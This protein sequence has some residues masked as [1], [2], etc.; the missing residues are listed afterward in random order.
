[1]AG[2]Q[3][4]VAADPAVAA[5]EDP[6]GVVSDLLRAMLTQYERVFGVRPVTLCLPVGVAALLEAHWRRQRQPLPGDK[7]TNVDMLFGCAV[8]F[9]TEFR[10]MFGSSFGDRLQVSLDG[11][12]TYLPAPNGVRTAYVVDLDDDDSEHP[13]GRLLINQTAEGI[14]KDVYRHTFN[15]GTSSITVEE[16]VE[17][18]CHPAEDD[19]SLGVRS[20][21]GDEPVTEEDERR[22]PYKDWQAIVRDGDTRLGYEDWVRHR[23]EAE[24]HDMEEAAMPVEGEAYAEHVQ[25]P[26]V[27]RP[28]TYRQIVVEAPKI[29]CDVMIRLPGGLDWIQ[30]QLRPSNAAEGYNGSLDVILPKDQAVTLWSG[31]SMQPSVATADPNTRVG[32]QLVTELPGDYS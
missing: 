31:D 22:H 29:D 4:H 17:A 21:D 8:R 23:K 24:R 5:L 3:V 6:G 11:G 16:Q 2:N 15:M 25:L 18:L 19:Q 28:E 30:V 14:I 26:G 1:M 27:L 7:I 9:D 10:C 13:A 20:S 32:K 12:D